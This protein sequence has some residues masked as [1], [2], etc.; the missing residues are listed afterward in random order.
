MVSRYR[1]EIDYLQLTLGSAQETFDMKGA[2]RET[3]EEM[4]ALVVYKPFNHA[5]PCEAD[6]RLATERGIADVRLPRPVGTSG[7]STRVGNLLPK[8]FPSVP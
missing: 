2:H 3:E 5:Y 7:T 4:N 1:T 8:T 6:R